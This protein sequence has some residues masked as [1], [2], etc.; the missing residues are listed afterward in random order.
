MNALKKE[1]RDK[2]EEAFKVWWE[3]QRSFAEKNKKQ[4][5]AFIEAKT[6]YEQYCN[7]LYQQERLNDLVYFCKTGKYPTSKKY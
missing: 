6:Q 7:E 5:D 1:L 2:K 3:F 4:F